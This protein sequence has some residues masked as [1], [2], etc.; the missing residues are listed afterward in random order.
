MKLR[1]YCPGDCKEIVN[2]FYETVHSVNT[3]GYTEPQT[4]EWAS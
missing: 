2:L 3:R 1:G 4:N